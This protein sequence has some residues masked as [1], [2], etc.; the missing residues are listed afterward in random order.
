M[1]RHAVAPLPDLVPRAKGGPAI[2]CGSGR[3]AHGGQR[4]DCGLREPSATVVRGRIPLVAERLLDRHGVEQDGGIKRF[5]RVARRC[6]Q[7]LRDQLKESLFGLTGDLAFRA[8]NRQPTRHD[9]CLRAVQ[10]DSRFSCDVLVTEILEEMN[11][12]SRH[13]QASGDAMPQDVVEPLEINRVRLVDV[14]E[15]RGYIAAPPEGHLRHEKV[16]VWPIERTAA[17]QFEV[18]HQARL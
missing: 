16:V 9:A 2:H 8:A 14:L 11:A 7:R 17:R 13:E 12:F 5:Q 10:N 3:V 4:R 1:R 6:R 18:G 15:E